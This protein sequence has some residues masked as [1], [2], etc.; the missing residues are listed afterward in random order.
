VVLLKYII[1]IDGGGTKTEAAAYS[2]EGLELGRGYSGFGNMLLGEEIAIMNI[3]Q[4]VKECI[5][6]VI[7]YSPSGECIMLYPGI[8]GIDSGSN[9]KRLEEVLNSQFNV[10]VRVVND[11]EIALAALLKGEDGVLTISGTGSISYGINNGIKAR[12]GGWG[13][14]LGD[15]GSGYFIAMQVFKNMAGDHDMGLNIG[16][17]SN[18]FMEKLNITNVE[19]IK[20]FIYSSQKGEIAAL[21]P[22]VARE[23]E[24]GDAIAIQILKQAGLDLSDITLRVCRKL[25]I[26]GSVVVGIKGSILTRVKLVREEFEKQLSSKIEGLKIIENEVSPAKGGYYL[27]IK[28]LQNGL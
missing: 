27:G 15:E 6:N 18:V 1:G 2:L 16:R 26:K 4:A 19:E 13:H 21:A 8:A 10:R 25:N 11:A 22:L 24:E 20:N 23:A 9:R 5:S 17:L 12:G 7:E 28:E 14:L 3:T